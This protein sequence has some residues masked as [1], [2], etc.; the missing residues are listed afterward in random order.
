MES[1]GDEKSLG[2][3]RADDKNQAE[4]TQ[5]LKNPFNFIFK[6]GGKEKKPLKNLYYK[7]GILLVAGLLLMSLGNWN[8]PGLK[9]S[10]N[11]EAENT[12]VNSL[13]KA[14]SALEERL[15]EI[16]GSIKGAGQVKVVLTY[17]NY[18]RREYA[19]NEQES[20]SLINEEDIGDT[21]KRDSSI[22]TKSL[23]LAL[24]NQGPVILEEFPPRVQGVLIVAEGAGSPEIKMELFQAARGL[25]GLPA[26]RI[27]IAQGE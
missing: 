10:A 16:L 9:S 20:E 24:E 27:I 11:I 5:G 21:S 8:I 17:F 13:P 6:P 3:K 12:G 2:D 1:R 4:K 23:D 7:L 25:L 14:E 18:G 26:H 22:V 19:F 15:A